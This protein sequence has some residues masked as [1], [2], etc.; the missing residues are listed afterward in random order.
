LAEYRAG[1][2]PC[3]SPSQAG[4]CFA[5]RDKGVDADCQECQVQ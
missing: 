5:S 3:R 1:A 4:F 2:P